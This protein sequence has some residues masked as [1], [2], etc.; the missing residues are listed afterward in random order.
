MTYFPTPHLREFAPD[1][2]R[3]GSGTA[4]PNYTSTGSPSTAGRDQGRPG[5]RRRR[6]DRRHPYLRAQSAHAGQLRDFLERSS[7]APSGPSSTPRPASTICRQTASSCSAPC[8]GIPRSPSSA[9]PDTVQI[10]RPRRQDPERS[11]RCTTRLSTRSERSAGTVR[12]SPI[13][14]TSRYSRCNH[15]QRRA[16][17][18]AVGPP[19]GARSLLTAPGPS[20]R[21]RLLALG[22]LLGRLR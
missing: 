13:L 15:S 5:C 19:V 1:G 12:R 21:D 4:A 22:R 8:R 11:W 2:F 16:S 3:S 6:G 17:S 7:P 9:A 14:P 20:R 18:V 10:R